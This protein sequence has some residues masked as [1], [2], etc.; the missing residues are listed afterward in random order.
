MPCEELSMNSPGATPRPKLTFIVTAAV[1]T[2]FFRGQLAYMIGNGFDVEIVSSPGPELDAARAEGATSRAVP[3]EREMAPLKDLV[4]LWRL[5]RLFRRIDPDLVVAGTPKAGLLGTIAARLARVPHVVYTLHGLR[6]ETASGWRRPVLWGT[7]WLACHA[8]HEVRS[9]S[10]SLQ[11]RMIGLGL[12]TPEHCRVVGRGTS[13]GVNIEHWQRTPLSDGIAMQ[14]RERL[15][16]PPTAPLVGFVGRLT[17]DK[18]MAE[19]YEAFTHLRRSHPDLRLLLVG[20]FEAGDPV[21]PALRAQIDFNPAVIVTGFVTDVAPY[22]WTMDVLALPTY[23]EGFPGVPLEAQAASVPVVTTDATG[24]ADAIL[25]GITGL[26]IPVGDSQ[27][28]IAALDRL[29]S[30]PALR[31]RMGHA[32]C[33]WVQENFR[34]EVVWQSLLKG[35][36]AI[37]HC[38][39]PS[40]RSAGSVFRTMCERVIAASALILGTPAML[41]AAIAI[42]CSMGS[43]ILFRQ[44]RPG[45]L[46]RPFTLFKFRTMRDLKD[47]TGVPLDD[48]QRLTR[49]GRLLRALSADELP[50]LWNVLRGEM[51]LVGPRPLLSQYIDRYTPEQARRHEV[52]PGITGWAQVNGRNA[53]SWEEKFALD[54]WYV[55]HRNLI[56][57]LRILTL[58]LRSLIVHN[59]VSSRNHAT[60]PEFMGSGEGENLT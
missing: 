31:A 2:G 41:L 37:L 12:T 47:E 45:L 24:A 30:D 26:H 19:L 56:L 29:L 38:D 39:P 23:R 32:G 14:T 59:D 10:T 13:N 34:R 4:S 42:R 22:Y 9:V 21:P 40:R 17:R 52:L 11:T 57:D 43:P 3:M 44:V 28:L 53:I 36:R 1:S 25:N 5:W 49:L 8:A 7:E 54:V 27:A 58:T 15:R 60:M 20:D 48:S 6:L 35:Y 51:S 46:S 55:D 50:Q 18:G 16:I 33:Q